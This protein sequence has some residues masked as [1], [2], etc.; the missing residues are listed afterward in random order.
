MEKE[1][2]E[3]SVMREKEEKAKVSGGRGAE[4]NLQNLARGEAR[5]ESGRPPRKAGLV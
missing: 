1:S 2:G 5:L 3:E 4:E